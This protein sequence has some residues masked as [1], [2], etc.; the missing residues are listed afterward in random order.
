M[1]TRYAVYMWGAGAV[2]KVPLP[3][4]PERW[5][6]CEAQY[7]HDVYLA[8][9]P[10]PRVL[11]IEKVHG[12]E[13]C[14]FERIDGQSMWGALRERHKD[15]A[16]FGREMGDLHARL[17]AVRP[18]V[19]LPS[20][21]DRIAS[22]IR[23]AANDF[24]LDVGRLLELLPLQLPSVWLCHGD[25]HPKNI[26]MS[27][28]GLFV[29]D[30]FDASRGTPCAEVARSALLIAPD[31]D[32]N[33]RHGHLPGASSDTLR[34]LHDSY[35]EEIQAQVQ[36]SNT[37]FRQWGYLAAAARLAEG[38]DPRPLLR[39]LDGFLLNDGVVH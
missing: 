26:V 29:V 32:A 15:A 27:R 37:D 20:Q 5:I 1:G 14:I 39:I 8:G 25:F 22:K 28:R 21:L 10:V 12:R 19:T 17:L 24:N 7:A 13:V 38:V 11:G 6:V 2:A 36:F 9:A 34:L 16:T 35:L 30:W 23:L 4:T 33:F 31:I 18:P 3:L